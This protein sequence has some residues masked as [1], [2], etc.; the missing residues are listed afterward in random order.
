MIENLEANSSFVEIPIASLGNG[1][2]G[3][4]KIKEGNEEQSRSYVAVLLNKP[5][6]LMK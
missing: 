5:L 6:A 1:Q 2:S 4:V 3:S